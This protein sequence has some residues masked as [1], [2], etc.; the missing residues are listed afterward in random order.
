MRRKIFYLLI[1]HYNIRFHEYCTLPYTFILPN[2]FFP[3]VC[4][5]CAW[6]KHERFDF[7]HLTQT[8]RMELISHTSSQAL[9]CICPNTADVN[10]HNIWIF[11]ANIS[12][13]RAKVNY[14]TNKYRV[15]R[16]QNPPQPHALHSP[17]LEQHP[18]SLSAWPSEE[19]RP[20]ELPSVTHVRREMFHANALSC[21]HKV[22]E[23]PLWV[24]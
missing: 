11:W 8:K 14:S 9:N 23:L 7:S 6:K 3:H 4:I 24:E 13:S 21:M 2:Y 18:G 10:F 1:I 12:K 20:P 22:P 16:T 5:Y 19:R 17:D 15:C